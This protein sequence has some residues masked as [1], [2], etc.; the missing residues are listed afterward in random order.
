MSRVPFRFH[1]LTGGLQ[2]V[3]AVQFL[4][5]CPLVFLHRP[6]QNAFLAFHRIIARRAGIAFPE[7]SDPLEQVGIGQR[8]LL[9]L[10][11][12][13]PLSQLLQ[14]LEQPLLLTLADSPVLLGSGRAHA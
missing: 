11:Q 7:P 14:I 2:E 6:D 1:V 10:G 13:Y 4:G 5:P 8:Q 12:P 3:G 9:L